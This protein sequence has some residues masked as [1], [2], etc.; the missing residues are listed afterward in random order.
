MARARKVWTRISRILSRE[1]AAPR[2]YVLFFKSVVQVVLLFGADTY[3]VTS[4]MGKS[5]GGGGG[6]PSWRD[7]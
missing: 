4:R 5:L 6:R 1:G 2:V 7:V 3:V